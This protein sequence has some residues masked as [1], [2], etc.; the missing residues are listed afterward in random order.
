MSSKSTKATKERTLTDAQGREIAVKVLNQDII[1]RES[2]INKAM[3]CA[4]KL[5]DR[6]ISDKQKL[7]GIVEG[8]LNEAARRN[9][10]EWKG[11]ALL[12]SFD[13]KYRIE[14]RYREKIQFGIELQLASRR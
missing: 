10:L 7:I 2:A 14:I 5:Q 8:Y 6:I 11:N 13:E 4:I 3:D 9:G 12:I 1:E